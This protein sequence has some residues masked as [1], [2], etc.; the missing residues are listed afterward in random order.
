MPDQTV[1]CRKVMRNPLLRRKQMVVDILHPGEGI[2]KHSAITQALKSA[3]R[4]QD[5]KTIFLFNF[6]TAFGGG[7]SSG[8]ALIYDNQADAIK[9]EPKYRLFRAG[10]ATKDESKPGRKKKKDD[11]GVKRKTW[12]TGRR[13]RLHKQKKAEAA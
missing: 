11:K 10:L 6:K 12:G 4:V 13:A 5:E 7:S 8:F 3:F 2:M 9:F 1:R